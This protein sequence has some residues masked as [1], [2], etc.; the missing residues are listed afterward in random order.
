MLGLRFWVTE[1]LGLKIKFASHQHLHCLWSQRA[2]WDN[3]ENNK[4]AGT[5]PGKKHMGWPRRQSKKCFMKRRT[6]SISCCGAVEWDANENALLDL[7]RW[8][9]LL[10]TS[11]SHWWAG[12]ESLI[13]KV[14]K[15]EP[16]LLTQSPGSLVCC[17]AWK[18]LMCWMESL[19]ELWDQSICTLF[20][21]LL[22][23]QEQPRKNLNITTWV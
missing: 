13:R 23:L 9:Y 17:T 2:R 19:G 18:I 12:G 7:A 16:V 5:E 14:G 3:T 15:S 1:M 4:K 11:M 21:E 8:R 6:D 10:V 20:L 22:S